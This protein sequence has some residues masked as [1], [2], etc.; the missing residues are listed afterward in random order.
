MM[1]EDNLVRVSRDEL[2]RVQNADREAARLR[3]RN[4]DLEGGFVKLSKLSVEI[5]DDLAAVSGKLKILAD[6]V[7]ALELDGADPIEAK[8][9]VRDGA[10]TCSRC[11]AVLT[12]EERL[13]SP[14][15]KR[16]RR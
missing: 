8:V 3:R 15:R 16:E 13:S 12:K 4:F 11:G 7:A 2:K 10:K 9:L 6:G 14:K 1:S 5:A